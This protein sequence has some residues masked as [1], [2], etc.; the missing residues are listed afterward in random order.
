MNERANVYPIDRE[1]V[2]YAKPAHA[3]RC[4]DGNATRE[5]IALNMF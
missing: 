2:A 5:L 3:P 4:I 1:R